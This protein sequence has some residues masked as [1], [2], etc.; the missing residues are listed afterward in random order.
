MDKEHQ[1]KV[2]KMKLEVM[3]LKKAFDNRIAEF[4]KQIEAYKQNNEIIEALKKAH[5]QELGAHVQE[6]NKKYNILLQDKLE[7]ED[8]MKAKHKAEIDQLNAD[9]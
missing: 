6:H 4:K 7:G 9:W 1:E 3:E 2:N 5:A 8:A